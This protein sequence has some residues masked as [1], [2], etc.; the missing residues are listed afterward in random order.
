[1]GHVFSFGNLSSRE[2]DVGKGMHGLV[3]THYVCGTVEKQFREM[4]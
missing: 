4:E 1:M 2:L 3:L